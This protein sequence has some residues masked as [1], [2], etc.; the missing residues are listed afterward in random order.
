[1]STR[2]PLRLPITLGVGMIVLIV[3]LAIGWVLLSV[4]GMFEDPKSS[5][6]YITLLSA[7]TVSLA[8]VLVGTVIYLALTVKAINLNRRQAN[9][10]DSVT[11]ELKSPIASLKLYLQTLDR[12]P[13]S[14][15]ERDGFY[16][17]MLE[18]VERLDELINH[19][20]DAA[21]LD[22]EITEQDLENVDVAQ[23]LQDCAHAVCIRYRVP[24]ETIRLQ[25]QPCIVRMRRVDADMIFRNL[26]DNALKYAGKPPEVTVSS[27]VTSTG[28]ARV[29]VSD[30]GAGIPRKLR[31]K[32]FGRFV[33]VGSELE[34]DTP[35]TGLG[36]YIVRTLV[37]RHKGRVVVN[38]RKDS[39]TTF[40]VEL[41][42][43]RTTL[44]PPSAPKDPSPADSSSDESQPSDGES[45]E[46]RKAI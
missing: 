25:L 16:G 5:A 27:R 18:D 37:K 21:R 41:P 28:R 43:A 33:R 26:I 35:G 15:A 17:Y 8:L 7:G 19:L 36:L 9:F 10:I 30:N 6:L 22:K 11:H 3:A 29:Q 34:R 14:D 12:R 4:Y 40:D 38:D 20:L 39:G 44:E 46:F 2:R 42:N 45:A 13:V 1:M 31:R 23:L 24:K 32:I